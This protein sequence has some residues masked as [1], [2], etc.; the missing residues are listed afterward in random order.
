MDCPK[1]YCFIFILS[2]RNE[3]GHPKVPLPPLILQGTMQLLVGFCFSSPRADGYPII[4]ELNYPRI[5]H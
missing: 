2:S 1:R 4:I 5:V 3:G